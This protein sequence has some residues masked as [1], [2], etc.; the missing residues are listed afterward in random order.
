[1]F[2]NNM[3]YI[4]TFFSEGR[5]NHTGL[6]NNNNSDVCKQ[7]PALPPGGGLETT[8]CEACESNVG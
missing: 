2:N 3:R 7:Y 8:G 5:I 6:F 4:E 1:M